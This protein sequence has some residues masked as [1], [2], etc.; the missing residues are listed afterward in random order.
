MW[1]KLFLRYITRLK[2]CTNDIQ[3]RQKTHIGTVILD[4]HCL[5]ITICCVPQNIW[6]YIQSPPRPS[7]RPSVCR[8]KSVWVPTI[9]ATPNPIGLKLHMLSCL[10]PYFHSVAH[11]CC[12]RAEGQMTQKLA[13]FRGTPICFADLLLVF[14][15][16]PSLRLQNT[17]ACLSLLVVI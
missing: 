8:L 3:Q 14:L 12:H 16:C 17:S 1:G 2:T 13:Q 5:P 9:S 11:P 4:F 6:R 15:R 7:V 10:G